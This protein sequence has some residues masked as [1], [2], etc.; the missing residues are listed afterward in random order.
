MTS[1][2]VLLTGLQ[3]SYTIRVNLA[4]P[5][6]TVMIIPDVVGGTNSLGGALRAKCRYGSISTSPKN[7]FVT[8]ISIVLIF[9]IKQD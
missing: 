9:P 6:G 1:K 4:T 8:M 2:P 5:D 7:S 3:G